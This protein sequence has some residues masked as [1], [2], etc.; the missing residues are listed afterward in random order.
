[1]KNLIYFLFII[2]G[3][4]SCAH[5]PVAI[6]DEEVPETVF[7][8]NDQIKPFT[9]R[10]VIYF[11]NSK[12]IKE[13]MNYKNGILHGPM[14][15]YYKDGSIRRR[16]MFV[17]GKME[18]K[19]ESWYMDGK[20]YYT[21][22]YVCDSLDGEYVEWYSTGVMKE[23]GLYAQ[24]KPVGHWIGYDEAGMIIRNEEYEK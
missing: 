7:Y 4:Y 23:K 8:C 17:N 6:T 10:C 1:M 9:G 20:M 12:D 3:F 21:A 16:G 15:S 13:E 2:L 5:S 18:G 11:N 14:I 22:E 19:W 24:N